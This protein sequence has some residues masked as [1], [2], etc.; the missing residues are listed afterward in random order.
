M[1]VYNDFYYWPSDDM[2]KL[3]IYLPN[4]YFESS[5]RYPVMY[6]FDGH[7]LFHDSEATYGKSWG[8]ESFMNTWDKKMIIVGME[9]SHRDDERL[10]E[11]CPYEKRMFGKT[12]HGIGEKTFQWIINDVKPFIDNNFRT[13][14]HREATGIGGS[15]MGGIMSMYGVLAHNDVFSKAAVVS[16][17]VFWN[18]KN[19]RRSYPYGLDPDTRIYIS[20]GE[21][22]AGKA[23]F[24]GN[25]EFDT[26]EARSVYKFERELQTMD[27]QTYHYFQWDGKHCEA[28]WEKQNSIFMNFLWK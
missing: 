2:R 18:L 7:N 6:M 25:P 10:F 27:V 17:S 16:S 5:E 21:L 20:W 3:H 26:R 19:Y 12:I 11:Y 23:A 4:D 15:S 14:G 8:L 13:Y 9:C 28:D 1:I 24:G 22:E